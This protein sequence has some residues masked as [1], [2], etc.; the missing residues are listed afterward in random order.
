VLEPGEPGSAEG[1][2][3]LVAGRRGLFNWRLEV[4]GR[5]AHSGLNYWEGKSA[6]AAAARW[7]VEAEALSR[8][9]GGPTVSAGRL[10]AGEAGFV[11]DLAKSYAVLGSDRQLN[12]VPDRAVAEGE[13][14]FL[15]RGDGEQVAR[16]LS[17]MAKDIGAATGTALALACGPIIPPVD[18]Q[19]PQRAWCEGAVRLAAARG[20]RLEIEDQRG[21]IS[22]PNFLPYPERLTVLDGLGP[23]GG[24]MHTRDE[25]VNLRSLRRRIVLLA[26]LLQEDAAA[27]PDKNAQGVAR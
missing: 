18:P 25:F 21:G 4:R 24:G 9:G 11:G 19:G 15:S 12:M 2:E 14:R 20:W 5:A 22:F 17:A 13:V 26:D 16:R 3:T 10:I 27:S 8:P 6:L 23:I 1:S 7:C